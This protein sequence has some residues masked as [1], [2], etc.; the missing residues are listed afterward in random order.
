VLWCAPR[1]TSFPY[2]TLFRSEAIQWHQ[3]ARGPMAGVCAGADAR[4]AILHELRDEVRVP[5]FVT[6]VHF[7]SAFLQPL[8]MLVI[9]DVD[10][11]LD[12]KSTRLNS[13]H[14]SISYAV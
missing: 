13:S 4:V 3:S 9:A 8:A 11:E 12:R 1:S 7:L 10:V 2:T 14:V 5:H 6:V